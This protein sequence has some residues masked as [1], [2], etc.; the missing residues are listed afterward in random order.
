[1]GKK[2]LAGS[3]N[4]SLF[5]IFVFSQTGAHWPKRRWFTALDANDSGT[6]PDASLISDKAGK[7]YGTRS[8][9]R[10]WGLR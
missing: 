9:Q 2:V 8:N 1:M 6:Q 4:L 5:L 7:V 10:F 3:G